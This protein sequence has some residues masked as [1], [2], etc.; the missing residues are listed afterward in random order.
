M[1]LTFLRRGP[2]SSVL[3]VWTRPA[4]PGH[5]RS[6]ALRRAASLA[7]LAAALLVAVTGARDRG[8]SVLV[9]AEDLEAGQ[10]LG[11]EHL[12]TVTFPEALAPS[13]ALSAA[14]EAVGL[15]I[16][17]AA[18]AGEPVTGAR[19]LDARLVEALAGP[20]ATLVPVTLADSEVT[21]LLTHGDTVSIVT[22]SD[23][24][25]ASGPRVVAEGARVVAAGEQS[26]GSPDTVLVA[27][28]AESGLVV[29]AASLSHPLAVVLTRA[30]LP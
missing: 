18:T 21:A 30:P 25:G 3:P 22:V 12:D 6:V 14:D 16:T 17:A 5:H 7:L 4:G 27:L 26:T 11:P 28:D 13:A 8:P 9:F 29:A 19:L 15:A 23:D 2:G 1:T 20:D 24:P 10:I